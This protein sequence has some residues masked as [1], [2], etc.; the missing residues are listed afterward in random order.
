MAA[1]LFFALLNFALLYLRSLKEC[2]IKADGFQLIRSFDVLSTA[3][4]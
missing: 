3:H 2:F 4:Y 1:S